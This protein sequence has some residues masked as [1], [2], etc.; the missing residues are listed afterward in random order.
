M[1]LSLVIIVTLPTA[2]KF[3][4]T[5]RFNANVKYQIWRGI[6]IKRNNIEVYL[7]ENSYSMRFVQSEPS[8]WNEQGRWCIRIWLDVDE[9]KQGNGDGTSM[10][11]VRSFETTNMWLVSYDR[12]YPWCMAKML[13]PSVVTPYSNVGKSEWTIL[14]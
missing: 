3:N 6:A 9:R 5:P 8:M 1:H 2:W 13:I 11:L 14:P 12:L 4:A 10:K 7:L